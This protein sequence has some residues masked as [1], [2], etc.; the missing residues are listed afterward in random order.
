MSQENVEVVR[1]ALHAFNERNLGGVLEVWGSEAEWRPAFLGGGLLEGAVY[2]GHAGVR[3]FFEVQ[4]ETWESL[5]IDP[6]AT[7]DWG[8][9]VLIE[10][11][12]SA[13]GRASGVPV[14]QTTW[15]LF[16]VQDG[17]VA[18]GG[19]FITEQQ[20]LDAATRLE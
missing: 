2:R 16:E 9:F 7:R 19:V 8:D 11:R 13:L 14:N 6:R 15:N 5:S 3:E 12:L 1:Q 18:R 10:V 17:K 20:A 4:E